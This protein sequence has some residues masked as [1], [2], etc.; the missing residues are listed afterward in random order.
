MA[1]SSLVSSGY[2]KTVFHGMARVQGQIINRV[3]MRSLG[4][5]QGYV[6]CGERNEDRDHLFFAFP[7]TFTVWMN[8]AERLLGAAITYAG[9]GGHHRH[10]PSSATEQTGYHTSQTRIPDCHLC[11]MEGKK[12]KKTWGCL[13]FNG[14][15]N[16]GNRQTGEEPHYL[17]QVWGESQ[18]WGFKEET[19]WGFPILKIPYSLILYTIE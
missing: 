4:I 3:S 7:Y 10:P 19:V 5:E 12:L 17:S 6:F 13:C 1:L 2:F 8:V 9:L 18:A 11:H 14:H 16:P 15:D